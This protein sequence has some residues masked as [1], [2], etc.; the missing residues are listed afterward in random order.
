VIPQLDQIVVNAR[1]RRSEIA[2]HIAHGLFYALRRKLMAYFSSAII[3]LIAAPNP[4]GVGVPVPMQYVSG[5]L[6][7]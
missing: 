3:R 5:A 1:K 6:D 2:V 7:H 4:S